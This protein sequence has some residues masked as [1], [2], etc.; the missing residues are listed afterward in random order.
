MRWAAVTKGHEAEQ[1]VPHL[2]VQ[3]IS[4]TT[5]HALKG[6]PG[7]WL[8]CQQPPA[9][10]EQMQQNE[11]PCSVWPA[12]CCLPDSQSHGDGAAEHAHPLNVSSGTAMLPQLISLPV[13]GQVP[14]WARHPGRQQPAALLQAAS[15]RECLPGREG[16]PSSMPHCPESSQGRRLLWGLH[17]HT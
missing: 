3:H 8:C 9:A 2:T 14:T 12:E 10:S 11:G 5:P 7:H 13:E 6:T 16:V 15:E 1:Q 4:P 17:I